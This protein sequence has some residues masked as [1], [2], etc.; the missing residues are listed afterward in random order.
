M[1]D[2]IKQG[3]YV[4]CGGDFNHDLLGNSAELLNANGKD[5]FGWAQP[6]PKELIPKDIT[7]CIDYAD[8]QLVPTSRNCD[9]AYIKGETYVVIIDG[10]FIS[11]NV[12]LVKV[13][14]MD[15]QFA[16]SDHNPVLL[17]FKLK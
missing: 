11:S 1:D 10:F 7:M 5:E 13:Q 16:F 4:I 6:F 12:E 9:I 3:E 15:T 17:Q 8:K 14:N 2:K